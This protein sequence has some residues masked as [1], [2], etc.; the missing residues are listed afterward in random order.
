MAT[1]ILN[2]GSKNSRAVHLD[3]SSM[4]IGSSP[5]ADLHFENDALSENHA[6]IEHKT[7]GFYIIN[8]TGKPGVRVNGEEITFQK[9]TPG[10]AIEIADINAE[11]AGDDNNE[12]PVEKTMAH[13]V[14]VSHMAPLATTA[15]PPTTCPRCNAPVAQGMHS[16]PHCG[17]PLGNL[18]AMP[19]DYIPPTPAG[20]VGAGILPV[21]A[22]LAALTVV[23]AP[24]A[25]VLGLITLSAIKRRGG[26]KRDRLLAN[27]SIGLGLLWL[28]LGGVAAGG[29]M[30]KMQ[31]RKQDNV[32][33]N[34][35]QEVIKVL[36]NLACAQKYAH[37]IECFDSD[38]DG[39]GEYG[40]LADLADLK[41]PFLDA[42]ITDGEAYGYWFSIREASEEQFLAV[43]EP[44]HYGE[45][46]VRTFAIDQGGQIRGGD[47]EGKR[48]SQIEAT[49][50]VLQSQRSAYYE[51]DDG[52]AKDVMN[53]I[54]T[55]TS[56]LEEQ[57]KK[58]RI[59]LRLR[60]D[61]ALTTVG[62]ELEGMTDSV[63]RF[64]T[65][66]RAQVVYMEAKE[67]LKNG[68]QD[69]ALAK[70]QELMDDHTA[71]SQIASV[72]RELRDLR[73]DIA[74][75]REQEARDLL[76]K[77][78]KM[79]RTGNPREVEELYQRIE[80]LY[81]ETDTANRITDLKPE[82]QLQIRE[83]DAEN[84]FSEMM[85]LSTKDDCEEILN[86]ANQLHRSYDDT[87]F[88]DK[89]LA[90]LEEKER[91]ARANAW[92]IKTEQNMAEGKMR[93]ALAQLESA[94][95]ENPDLLYD[96]RDLSTKLYRGVADKLVE[97]GD[98][99][100]ALIYYERLN[101]LLQTSGMDERVEPE[102]LAQ[103][104]HDVGQADYERR[105]YKEARWHLASAA[106][107][108]QDDAQF[109]TRLGVSSLY[110]GFYL[111]ADEALTRALEI[112]PDMESTR[113]HR[114]YLNMR[115]VLAFE[116]VIAECF[117]QELEA[118]EPDDD[119]DS[120]AG[121]DVKQDEEEDEDQD[122]DNA[123][124][125]E[126]DEGE[127]KRKPRTRTPGSN[128]QTMH[129]LSAGAL[130]NATIPEPEDLDLVIH[131]DH[132]TSRE[133][134][135]DLLV[136]LQDLQDTLGGFDEE[137]R[138]A[139]R[140]D[141]R[142]VDSVKLGQLMTIS[143]IRN[144]L[145]ELRTRHL[146]DLDAQKELS[147]MIKEM[148][149]RAATSITDIKTASETEP[150]VL[151]LASTAALKISKKCS[152]LFEAATLI[153][154]SIDAEIELREKVFELAEEVVEK[155]AGSSGG[156]RGQNIARSIQNIFHRENSI[157]DIDKALLMLQNAMDV[158]VNL[159]DL[160]HA[161]DGNMP[162]TEAGSAAE[163]GSSE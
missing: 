21:I 16:C 46:G 61:Y 129:A 41:S 114:A 25:L 158:Q 13:P 83:R 80:K 117:G 157:G 76:A 97:D 136:F 34:S 58:Q 39:H 91:K 118:T 73:S 107:N 141:P 131:Y 50:P 162:A 33:E 40:D 113:L 110:S 55:L 142:E 75:R 71:F 85:E 20:Q 125:E 72:D 149:R 82:L 151:D 160:L 122:E 159:E 123:D 23:G 11:L 26:T 121:E 29:V 38:S 126:S 31:Q 77:A 132:G 103:L 70:L 90:E 133:I 134:M 17:Q 63:D 54:K 104:H 135:P 35:E 124:E 92:R 37:T 2:P 140:E 9:L 48:F 64:V 14:Q 146:K 115:V 47:A 139:M 101:R 24:I 145:S 128:S 150:R 30:R 120:D 148:K 109:N 153:T 99:R 144:E 43:A 68:E 42:E 8:L 156:S 53:H 12:P 28:M 49:L 127:S 32:V 78:E 96:L 59:L 67:A 45:S 147:R 87:D 52:I 3:K 161:A 84:I 89:V 65:E 7:D 86:L 19:M 111:P 36:K 60:K 100:E 5:D 119:E 106:W 44:I 62:Q 27:W 143:E 69:V 6:Q 79:E 74:Q 108:Y 155:N 95:R 137:L 57:E 152:Y 94:A 163:T 93:G 18:P 15:G 98:M 88:Y 154:S 56:T 102:L 51:L 130:Q 22:F 4:V 10:D 1:L 81:P 105:E 66:Q 138:E 116:Q 112:R